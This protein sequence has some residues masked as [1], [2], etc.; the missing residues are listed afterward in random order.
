MRLSQWPRY[1]GARLT[2]PAAVVATLAL[3]GDGRAQSLEDLRRSLSERLRRAHFASSFTGLVML[4]DE[5]ELST[6]RY[7]IDDAYETELSAIA[8]PF[9]TTFHPWGEG[10]TGLYV[11]GVVGYAKEEQRAADL[12]GGGLPGLETVVDSKSTTY[13]G[14]LGLGP[15]FDLGDGLTIA[16]IVNAGLSRI[17]NEAGYAGPGAEVSA[18]LLDGI[19]LNWDGWIVTGGGAT[20]ADW[21]LPLGESLELELVGRYDLRWTRTIES[22]D[23]AQEFSTRMQVAT[24]RADVVGPTGLSLFDGALGWRVTTGYRH[25]LEGELGGAKD[26]VQLGGSL[27]LDT[28]ENLP[29]G[30]LVSVSF[31]MVWGKN[32]TGVSVGAGISL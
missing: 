1:L 5:L 7:E 14:L 6:A 32:L 24:L 4:S 25:F 2:I 16:P 3:A 13:G 17:E 18:L 19:G 15:E 21:L 30:S 12:Y 8:L 22:D 29:V 20:R 28:G 23:G 9:H 31:A 11:E 26:L 10:A 27:E